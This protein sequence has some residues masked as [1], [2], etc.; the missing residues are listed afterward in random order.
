MTPLGTVF[1]L[2]Y[3]LSLKWARRGIVTVMLFS[4][5]FFDSVIVSSS[6]FALSPYYFGAILLLLMSVM[7]W[8]VRGTGLQFD[9]ISAALLIYSLLITALAPALFAG[10][11]V[12]ATE[13]GLASSK[14]D[15]LPLGYSTSNLAQTSYLT[16][17]VF[18]VA[19]V[20]A[21]NLINPRALFGALGSGIL[22][23]GAA[24]VCQ[25]ANVTWP[26]EFFWNSARNYYTIE[27]IRLSGQFSEPS[28]LG[29]YSL[30]CL[31]YFLSELILARSGYGKFF[32]LFLS[33]VSAICF[34]ASSTGTGFLGALLAS[35]MICVAV[36]LRATQRASGL[37]IPV[38]VMLTVVSIVGLSPILVSRASNALTSLVNQKVGGDSYQTRTFVDRQAL[39]IW[40]QS[41]GLGV[42]LGS[43]RASSILA[44]IL[45]TIGMVGLILTL[46]LCASSIARGMRSADTTSA[47]LSLI[48]FWCAAAVSFADFANPV[49]WILTA[50]AIG[51]RQV[52]HHHSHTC[53]R[54]LDV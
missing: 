48:S 16:L 28:H 30:V 43:N 19:A 39:E 35:A 50:Y 20:R 32:A 7:G 15:L 41:F 14:S 2:A 33:A 11:P 6:N 26:T 4:A 46:A 42:G 1:V 10:L 36:F 37:R 22:V 47:A 3:L 24:W 13:L 54:K 38:P 25:L 53:S 29:A 17:N 45:S 49:L 23:S 8:L 40:S 5:P 18:M 12:S 27:S 52:A 34:A 44:L 51:A 31:T 9:R 21:S